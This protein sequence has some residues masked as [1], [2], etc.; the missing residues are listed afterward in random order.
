VITS[1]WSPGP[2]LRAF[3]AL[4][5]T[6]FVAY[7][8]LATSCVKDSV[9]VEVTR[10]LTSDGTSP[11]PQQV[12]AIIRGGGGTWAWEFLTTPAAVVQ[13]SSLLTPAEFVAAPGAPQLNIDSSVPGRV[14]VTCQK[15]CPELLLNV[16]V[17][18]AVKVHLTA[19]TTIESASC[20]GELGLQ[21]AELVL[22]DPL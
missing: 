7:L 18:T 19:R 16:E 21:A 20:D 15:W 12:I 1:R 2:R 11:S 4:L 5:A 8:S 17:P 14:G 22:L 10:D 6:G 13:V 3:S 9:D